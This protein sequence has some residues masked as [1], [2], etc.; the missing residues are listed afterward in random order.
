V[1]VSATTRYAAALPVLAAHGLVPGPAGFDPGDLVA[2]AAARGWTATAEHLP[3]RPGTLAW[4]ATVFARDPRVVA[5]GVT[6]SGAY[7]S[8]ATEAEALAVALASLLRR[9]G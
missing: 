3:R 4:R 9:W 8:G 5:S 6:V 7:G 1:V 2:C